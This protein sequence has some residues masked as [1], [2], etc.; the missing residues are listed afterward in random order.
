[1]FILNID[2]TTILSHA[3][4]LLI[5]GTGGFAIRSAISKNVNK[6]KGNNSPIYNNEGSVTTGKIGDN[7]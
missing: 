7:K 5:G 4:T 6:T 1:M 2:W 3:I